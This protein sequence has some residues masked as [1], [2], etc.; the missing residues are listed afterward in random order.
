M[1]MN[2]ITEEAKGPNHSEATKMFEKL[3]FFLERQD[4][5]SSG[6]IMIIK[7]L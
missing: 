6:G 3:L 2:D 1:M 5:T 4:E 7:Q